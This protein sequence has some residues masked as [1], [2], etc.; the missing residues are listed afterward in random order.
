MIPSGLP[1]LEHFEVQENTVEF[2]IKENEILVELLILSADPYMRGRMK[3]NGEFKP[4]DTLSGFVSGKIIES[5]NEKWKVNELF[6]SFL[7][8]T[9]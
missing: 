7:P 5:K 6:G 1:E 8:F 2:I 3:G 9:S 4:G